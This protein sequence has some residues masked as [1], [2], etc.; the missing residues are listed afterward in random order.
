M[1]PSSPPSSSQ[2]NVD[3]NT[4]YDEKQAPRDE[5]F[6]HG[7]FDTDAASRI[8]LRTYLKIMFMIAVLITLTIWAILSIYWGEQPSTPLFSCCSL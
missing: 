1:Q 6:A 3:E 8:A 4:V 2:V 5:P 7:I